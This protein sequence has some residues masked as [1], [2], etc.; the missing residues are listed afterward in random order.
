MRR[1]RINFN[2]TV[3]RLYG[4]PVQV[5]ASILLSVPVFWLIMQSF[6]AALGSS[7]GFCVLMLT[8]EF[9]H[10]FAAR[11]MHLVVFRIQILPFHGYCVAEAPDDARQALAFASGGIVAQL[12]LWVM[13]IL[14]ARTLAAFGIAFGP[15]ADELMMTLIVGNALLMVANLIPSPPLDGLL[16]WRAVGDLWRSR[17]LLRRALKSARKSAD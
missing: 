8:H 11:R 6:P 7:L 16:I 12:A 3:G 2:P 4:A 10:A 1:F 15:I 5:H 9:G 13:A 14:V 17:Q